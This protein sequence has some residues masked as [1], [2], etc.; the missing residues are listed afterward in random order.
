MSMHDAPTA[1]RPW[2]AILGS[3]DELLALKADGAR[4]WL[5]HSPH[6]PWGWVYG[7]RIAAQ[8]LRAAVL[9]SPEGFEASTFQC[10]FLRPARCDSP[11]VHLVEALADTRRRAVRSV[12]VEQLG[13]EVATVT[14]TL[15]APQQP[16][17]DGV[18]LA[19]RVP[20]VELE[21]ARRRSF[22][23][24]PFQ[25][26]SFQRQLLQAREGRTAALITLDRAPRNAGEAACLMAYAADDLPTDAARFLFGTESYLDGEGT[27]LWSMTATYAMHF[28]PAPMGRE[29]L[30]H[31]RVKAV[32]GSRATI[33]G[34][35]V[36]VESG[37][38]GALCLQ[39]VM[40][41]RRRGV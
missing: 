33:E 23:G 4:R 30:F 25:V 2:C 31:T 27:A 10:A 26:G 41:R 24:D 8:A 19:E 13:Q 40:M 6:Y 37:R 9:S 35:V 36:D 5:G 14:T 17:G 20:V 32:L 7:G 15:D 22:R 3:S 12:R 28:S 16:D 38:V 21:A 11:R 18:V 39:Q 29:L 1:L 34:M